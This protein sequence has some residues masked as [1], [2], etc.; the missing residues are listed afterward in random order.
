M[1]RSK[2]IRSKDTNTRNAKEQ[3][4]E[5]K[6]HRSPTGIYTADRQKLSTQA[7]AFAGKPPTQA[8]AAEKRHIYGTERKKA[9]R[10]ESPVCTREKR[11]I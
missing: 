8:Y 1:K 6:A 5:P 2:R 10:I 7:Q 9:Q 4:V 11:C 3:L